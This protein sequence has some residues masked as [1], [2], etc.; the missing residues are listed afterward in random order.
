MT[1]IHKNLHNNKWAITQKGLVV[2]YCDSC[3]ISDVSVHFSAGVKARN[4]HK[5]TVHTWCIGELLS[6]TNFVGKDGRVPVLCSEPDLFVADVL[7][8]DW[9]D[10]PQALVRYNPFRDEFLNYA[11]S[12][13]EYVGSDYAVFTDDSEMW[14]I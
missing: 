9:F 1:R 7:A 14:A 13:V 12:G 3:I 5:R 10:Y 8:G 11:D 4:S 6:V 2:G